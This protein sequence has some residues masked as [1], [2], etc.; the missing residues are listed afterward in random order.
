MTDAIIDALLPLVPEL[1]WT[2][3]ALARAAGA[4]AHAG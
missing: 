2:R 4:A 3:L 1:G